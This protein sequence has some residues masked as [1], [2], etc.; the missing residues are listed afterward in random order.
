M[1]FKKRT[2]LGHHILHHIHN[3]IPYVHSEQGEPTNVKY[4][5]ENFYD[6]A[7]TSVGTYSQG[8]ETIKWDNKEKKVNLISV[9]SLSDNVA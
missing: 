9:L 5:I 2:L 3:Q 4:S 6:E 8:D 1:A 7:F